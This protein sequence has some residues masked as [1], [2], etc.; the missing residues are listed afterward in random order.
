VESK[1]L[2]STNVIY[3]ANAD[4]WEFY[5]RSYMGGKDYADGNYLTAYINEDTTEYEKRISS[6][7]CDNH[8]KNIVQIYNSFIWRVPPTRVLPEDQVIADFMKDAD[9][10]GRSFNAFMREA[11]AWASVYG[12][13]WIV[14]DKPE[15]VA[16]TRQDEIDQG[17]RPYLTLITPENVLDWKYERTVSGRYK[18]TMLKIRESVSGKTQVVRIWENDTITVYEDDGN[19]VVVVEQMDNPLGRIP[20]VTLYASRSPIRG[21]GVSDISDVADFQKAIYS[22]LSEVEQLIRISNHPSLALTESTDASAGA[23]GLVTMPDDM[24]SGLKPFLLQPNASSLS[25]VMESIDAK[26]ESINRISHMGGVRAT[27]TQA[28]S[29]VALQT[30]FQL[31]NTRL[32]EKADLLELAEEQIWEL[33]N[34]WQGTDYEIE[35]DY[36]DTFDIRDYSADLEY[37]QAAKASGVN[38][39]T[40]AQT[41]D[42]QIAS[43]VVGEEEMQTVMDE[44]DA[45]APIGTF[46]IVVGE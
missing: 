32:S 15:S 6:T 2:L 22:E 43:L 34:E 8:C 37:L 44:I 42:K 19:D 33:F 30:E 16:E 26:T 35:V 41:V 23:G 27:D 39:Q 14:V 13:C 38:S 46:P 29:G 40:F 21:I 7:P 24:E 9:L 4:R 3:D 25:G 1:E 10:D 45:A 12:H 18:L 31:L 28:K 36:P 20:A 5:L 17:L 11:G